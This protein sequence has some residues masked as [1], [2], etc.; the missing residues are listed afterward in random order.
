MIAGRLSECLRILRWEATDLAEELGRPP[1]EVARWLDGRARAPLAVAAWI[2]AL[3]KAH[4]ALP[5]PRRDQLPQGL[6]AGE[7]VDVQVAAGAIREPEPHGM[8]ARV[9]HMRHVGNGSNGRCAPGPN[10]ASV[11]GSV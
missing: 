7:F 11:E 10:T 8:A 6:G 9:T 2:E 5:P 3:V 1:G 4:K